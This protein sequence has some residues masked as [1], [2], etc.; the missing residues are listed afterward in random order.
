MK[1]KRLAVKVFMFNIEDKD[2]TD[3]ENEINHWISDFPSL[4][5]FS[6]E[7]MNAIKL[8]PGILIFLKYSYTV[9]TPSEPELSI[10]VASVDDTDEYVDNEFVIIAESKEEALKMLRNELKGCTAKMDDIFITI[11]FEKGATFIY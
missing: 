9:D 7:E 3:I 6:I 2:H 5:D 8:E 4:I 10:F 11:P 1:M